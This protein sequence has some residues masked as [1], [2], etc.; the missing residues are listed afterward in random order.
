M[1]TSA[2]YGTAERRD[3]RTILT[4]GISLGLITVA[5]VVVFALLSRL[6]AGPSEIVIQSLIVLAG[7]ALAMYLPARAIRPLTIDAI[8]WCIFAGVIGAWVFTFVDVAILRPVGLYHWTW[9]AIGGGSGWW[10]L[11]IWWMGGAFLAWL[12]AWTYAARAAAQ[13]EIRPVA[14]GLQAAGLA[15]VIALLL[16]LLRLAPL[17]AATTSLAFAISAV[18]QVP[19]VALLKRR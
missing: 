5:G 10:Y 4:A 18:L 7:G 9:D 16:G 15:L 2:S 14:L 19:L 11:P 17:N 12:G 13:P 3:A 6:L 1:T 8:G